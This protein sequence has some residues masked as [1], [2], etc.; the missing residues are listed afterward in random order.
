MENAATPSTQS[1]TEVLHDGSTVTIRPLLKQDIEL[2]RR[3]IE[4]LSPQ[5]RRYRFLCSLVTPTDALLR[6]LTEL[7]P[8]REAAL[9]ALVED[10]GATREVGV[11]RFSGVPGGKAEIAV[12][13][14]DEWQNKG[15]GTALMRRL[16]DL[17]R[18]RGIREFY[19]I[20]AWSNDHMRRLAEH[21]GFEHKADPE[22]A[23]QVV[24]TLQLASA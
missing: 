14:S 9:V 19:S 6:Q 23:T 22:D 20:D 4:G 24:Y 13:V 16:I 15:L 21:L 2:E 3:F 12:T 17:A 5:S 11:A 18:Q 1:G 7:D 8:Q 10:H